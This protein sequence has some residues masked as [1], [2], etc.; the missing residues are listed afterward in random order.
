MNDA[1]VRA[2][3][4]ARLFEH[5]KQASGSATRVARVLFMDEPLRIEKGEVTDKGSINQRAVLFHRKD[6]I[7]ALYDDGPQV[8][9]AGREAVA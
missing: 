7:Q 4:A 6:L 1:N 5:Q 8:I 3:I 9:K 2:Q